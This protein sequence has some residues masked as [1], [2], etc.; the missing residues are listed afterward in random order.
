MILFHGTDK[1]NISGILNGDFSLTVKATHGHRYGPGIYFTDSID[2]A[3]SY[4][5]C[6]KLQI[7][8]SLFSPYRAYY[9][10][11]PFYR[12]LHPVIP[13]SPNGKTY[14]VHLLIKLII[15]NNLRKT[16]GCYNIL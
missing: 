12:S 16:N 15:L 10:W 5:V 3:L 14:D 4:S 11:K 1:T 6:V 8:Y 13:C 7:C 9:G 2:K